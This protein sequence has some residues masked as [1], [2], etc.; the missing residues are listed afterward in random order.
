MESNPWQ[1]LDSKIVY[2]NPWIR[3]R[4]D[5]I[6]TPRGKPGIYGVVEA[7]VS[8]GAVAIT[9]SNEVV[10]VG[11]YR[12]PIQSYSWE[13]PMGGAHKNETPIEAIRRELNE[14]TGF[15][16]KHWTPLSGEIHL[17]N[18]ISN[19]RAYLF[20]AQGLEPTQAVPDE[21]EIISQKLM[22]FSE[23][24]N[25]VSRGEICDALSI[26]GILQAA[27]QLRL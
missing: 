19:E 21:A 3:V 17:S 22:P 24:L 27:R 16:A 8:V 4:E 12:Y 1:T 25:K 9:E 6:L 5:Q 15:T 26:I 23:A 10:V 7:G 20:L 14:E 2:E 18:C 11:Q 13:I